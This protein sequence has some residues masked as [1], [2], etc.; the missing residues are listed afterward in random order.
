MLR[1]D[2][3]EYG[4]G[5]R[6][7]AHPEEE[8]GGGACYG[9]FGEEAQGIRCRAERPIGAGPLQEMR[10]DARGSV[11]VGMLQVGIRARFVNLFWS[12][13]NA[14]TEQY[15]KEILKDIKLMSP[16]A[17]NYL[18]EK[19][20]RTW[21]RAY[22]QVGRCCSSVENGGCESYNAII[23]EARKK[24]I[25][26][27]LEELRMYMMN[28]LFTT[29]LNGWSSDV[30]PEIR[31]GL[32]EL[33]VNQRFWEVLPSGFNQFETRSGSEAYEVDLDKRTCSCRM[34]QLN[35]YGCVHFV[36][37]ISYLNRD[38]EKYV[39]TYFFK[40]MYMKTYHYK[41]CPMNGSKMWSETNYISPLPPNNRRM[42]DR[43][44]TKRVRDVS[45]KGGNHRFSKKGKKISCSL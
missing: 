36:A 43:P 25:I 34:W 26:T 30:S 41:N 15:F 5:D 17:S 24:P 22:Y 19:S 6:S 32:N 44:K 29:K 27:M 35:G 16:E 20:P 11:Q 13:C 7:G 23:V 4:E 9:G 18:M 33:K 40:A 42:P 12:A 8:G 2:I 14:T 21:S 37:A 1:A 39:D 10:Q 38:V 3:R 31:L 28:K 45:E